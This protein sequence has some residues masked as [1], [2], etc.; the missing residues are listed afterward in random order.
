MS[1]I[2]EYS[3]GSTRGGG[4]EKQQGFTLIE[5]LIALAISAIISALAYQAIDG[6]VKAQTNVQSHA[7]RMGEVQRAVWWMEQ[8][9]IQLVPRGVKDGFGST[10]SAYEYRAD[11]GLEFTRIAQLPTPRASGGLLRVGYQLK[12][13]TLY[14]LTWPVIDRSPDSKPRK[15]AILT[16]V[17]QFGVRLLNEK[18]QWVTSWPLEVDVPNLPIGG[19]E[20]AA[21]KKMPLP[22]ITEV[23][24]ELDD[25]GVLTRLFMGVS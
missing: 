22:K 17:K 2:N 19:G 24:L 14:R 3:F 5:L 13:E 7:E 10:L 21:P 8:D 23:T 9:L 15:V 1:P 4:R 11:L 20:N 6:V 16:G 25:L 18:S 12:E